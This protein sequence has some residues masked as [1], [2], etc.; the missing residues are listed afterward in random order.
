MSI[1]PFIK[2]ISGWDPPAF[3]VFWVGKRFL[4]SP[5]VASGSREAAPASG[6]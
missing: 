6:W 2:F 3:G 5:K 1:E 4:V